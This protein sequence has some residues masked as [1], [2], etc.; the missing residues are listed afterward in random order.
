[1]SINRV[2]CLRVLADVLEE[3]EFNKATALRGFNMSS[4]FRLGV[5]TLPG[6]ANELT[7][8]AGVKPSMCGTSLCVAG[9][10]A[11]E[12]GW[13]INLKQEVHGGYKSV[14][15]S[16]TSPGPKGS[17]QFGEPEWEEIGRE[18]L[19]LREDYAH[20]LFFSYHDDGEQAIEILTKLA[21]GTEITHGEWEKYRK[22]ADCSMGDFDGYGWEP[23]YYEDEDDLEGCDCGCQSD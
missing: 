19:G 18:F 16:Y 20:I 22:N 14:A 8:E 10:A 6:E 15:K 23:D 1:M 21:F 12:A 5:I 4:F 9:F 7:V 13:K 11:I 2:N 3:Q 17:V